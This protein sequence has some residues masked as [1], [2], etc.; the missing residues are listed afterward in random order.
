[1]SGAAV[2]EVYD[3]LRTAYGIYKGAK[4]VYNYSNRGINSILQSKLKK[5]KREGEYTILDAASLKDK[6]LKKLKKTNMPYKKKRV[7]LKQA[8]KKLRRI[9]K[10][11]RGRKMRINRPVRSELPNSM[12]VNFKSVHTFES[13]PA[14]GATTRITWRINNPLDPWFEYDAANIRSSTNN[15][16]AISSERHPKNWTIWENLYDNFEVISYKVVAS[17]KATTEDEIIQYFICPTSAQE[18]V[19][20]QAICDAA[21]NNHHVLKEFNKRCIVTVPSTTSSESTNVTLFRKGNIRKLEGFRKNRMTEDL[22][23]VFRGKTVK[24]VDGQDGPDREP[25][26]YICMAPFRATSACNNHY[27]TVT[28]YQTVLFTNKSQQIG[29]TK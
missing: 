15:I 8:K 1:M 5:R 16:T 18:A 13:N 6:I 9:K 12:L 2:Q 19:E 4:T 7:A 23:Q 21:A 24:H 25:F 28:V 22:Q 11:R 27:I 14:A 3:A 10:R 17:W 20:N 29:A 26:V